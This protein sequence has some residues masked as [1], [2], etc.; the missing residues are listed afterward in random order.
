MEESKVARKRWRKE[1][2]RR[3]M[4]KVRERRRYYGVGLLSLVEKHPETRKRPSLES[5]KPP[6]VKEKPGI[7]G[8]LWKAMGL[9]RWE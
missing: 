4:R 1:L 5:P 8:W 7:L 9:E 2:R 6:N 3:D